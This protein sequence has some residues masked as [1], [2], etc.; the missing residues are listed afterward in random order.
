MVKYYGR[1][2]QR[3]GSVNTNQIGLNMSGCPSKV[4]RQGYLSKYIAS[5][6]Q[7]NQK[8]C[9]PVY[10]HGVIWSQNTERCVAKAPRGQSFN[11]GVGHKSTPRF[12]CGN[13]CSTDK[14]TTAPWWY[15]NPKVINAIQM[16]G[17]YLAT[18]SPP[19]TLVLFAEKETFFSDVGKHLSQVGLSDQDHFYHFHPH[20][21]G[22][23]VS[24]W[25][26]LPP[27]MQ[28]YANI[29]NSMKYYDTVKLD[30]GKKL[31]FAGGITEDAKNIM[32]ETIYGHPLRISDELSITVYGTNFDCCFDPG[33]KSQVDRSN[34][35]LGILLNADGTFIWPE[36]KSRLTMI[37]SIY[38][39]KPLLLQN[40]GGCCGYC[41]EYNYQCIP[42]LVSI[43]PYK[44]DDCFTKIQTTCARMA[45]MCHPHGALVWKGFRLEHKN[46]IM[47]IPKDWRPGDDIP[48]SYPPVYHYFYK[49]MK[50][51]LERGYQQEEYEKFTAPGLKNLEYLVFYKTKNDGV[52]GTVSV[53][54]LV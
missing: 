12:A 49:L 5:R 17:N 13:T 44:W 27:M 19:L 54:D 11:S 28:Y 16:L 22:Q 48:E 40:V 7:C 42:G 46:E 43:I 9:G 15:D 37:N 1:A 30:E 29:I 10:Y 53:G 26:S 3:I 18:L 2:R 24:D 36:G 25:N 39:Y 35:T 41:A 21:T 33:S 23:S 52:C 8:Y 45:D 6:V 47:I 51:A 14:N 4:G 32:T 20:S 31:H 50:K 38:A 34:V